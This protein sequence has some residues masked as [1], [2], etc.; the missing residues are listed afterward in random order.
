MK[1]G[2]GRI[3]SAN[4]SLTIRSV[5]EETTATIAVDGVYTG[6]LSAQ[7]LLDDDWV[8]LA[9]L[10]NVSTGA[11]SGTIASA[12]TG[13]FTVGIAGAQQFRVIGLSGITGV[14]EVS[15]KLID[16]GGSS[17]TSGS[18]QPVSGT[19]T[20]Q[21]ATAANLNAQVVGSTPNLSANSG[22][23][24][25]VAGVFNSALPTPANGN[26]L[27]LQLTQQGAMLTTPNISGTVGDSASANLVL[28]TV[29]RLNTNRLQ[30][31]P[32]LSFNGATWDRTRGDVNGTVQQPFAFSSSRWQYAAA[33]G[34]ISNTTTAVTL[35]S[36][37]G[38]GVRNYLTALQI[39]SD[40]LGAATEVVIR[41]GAGGT[42][43]WR[44]KIGTA[45]IAGIQSISLQC[46]LRGSANTLLEVAT[47]T[48]S[49]TGSVYINAQGFQG[50]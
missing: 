49:V 25:K 31:S 36:A 13:I 28:F 18:T 24:V 26:I 35:I 9:S 40:A 17:N 5:T 43:L 11:T 14:A 48:A 15:L 7:I 8:T 10:T 22:N 4:T 27:D 29:D 42:V 32:S 37:G 47:L 45:G 1:T 3:N 2:T 44:G 46:P 33:S 20:V 16:G 21:Q 39:S 41:D 50:S 19:V 23:P 6:A 34:G 38:A 12:A 30:A